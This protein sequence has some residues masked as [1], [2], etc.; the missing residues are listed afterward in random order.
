MFTALYYYSINFNDFYF[1]ILILTASA[2]VFLEILSDLE[3]L[4]VTS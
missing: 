2:V 3:P 4:E 1:D